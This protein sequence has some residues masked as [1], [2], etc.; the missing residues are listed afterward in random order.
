MDVYMCLWFYTYITYTYSLQRSTHLELKE[1]NKKKKL[2]EIK[3]E[4]KNKKTSPF[5]EGLLICYND[6]IRNK[7]KARPHYKGL[8]A[9][10]HSLTSPLWPLSLYDSF[11]KEFQLKVKGN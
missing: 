5:I 4:K 1:L 10:L 2:P 7:S 11:R 3:K 6:I 8:I 9:L